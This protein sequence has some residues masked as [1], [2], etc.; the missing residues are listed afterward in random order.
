M[1]HLWSYRGKAQPGIPAIDSRFHYLNH[2]DTFA[3]IRSPST[4]V[5]YLRAIPQGS[6]DLAGAD[7]GRLER[8]AGPA[9][10]PTS[11]S[12]NNHLYPEHARHSRPCLAGRRLLNTSTKQG[13]VLPPADSRAC[14]RPFADFEQPPALA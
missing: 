13:T 8:P 10:R 12:R 6:D 9:G 11:S 3:D 5:P 7:A 1:T 4:T 2:F 14:S